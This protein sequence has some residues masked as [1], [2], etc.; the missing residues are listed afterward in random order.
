MLNG[1]KLIGIHKARYFKTSK[2]L[3]LGPGPFI[4]ALEHATGCR[5]AVI[6]K[7]QKSFFDEVIAEIATSGEGDYF[8]IGDVRNIFQYVNLLRSLFFGIRN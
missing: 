6:G 3:S 5:A 1:A 4:T 7:P 8:M 2:D